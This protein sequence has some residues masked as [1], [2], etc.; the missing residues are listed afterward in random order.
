MTPRIVLVLGSLILILGLSEALVRVP[1]H[2]VK[3][4]RKHLHE[5]DTSINFV[6]RRWGSGGK[7]TPEPLSNYLVSNMFKSVENLQ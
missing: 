6:R 7:P 5:V 4:A 3:T 2:R 1:L